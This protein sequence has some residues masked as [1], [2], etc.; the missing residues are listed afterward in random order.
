MS[1][2]LCH[3]GAAL[4]VSCASA[5]PKQTCIHGAA[6]PRFIE[7]AEESWAARVEAAES[8][9]GE[10]LY[11]AHRKADE[12]NSLRARLALLESV[13]AE[14]VGALR[15]IVTGKLAEDNEHPLGEYASMAFRFHNI[16]RAALKRAAE[17]GVNQ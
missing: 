9:A 2:W 10:L 12:C 17:A 1:I 11:E 13:A 14:L 3:C 16:A 6:L 8:K 15:E 7:K 4:T 5:E